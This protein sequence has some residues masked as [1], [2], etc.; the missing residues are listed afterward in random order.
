MGFFPDPNITTGGMAVFEYAN[1]VTNG[2]FG[3]VI[4]GATFGVS[5][6]S[7]SGYA[8]EKT[9][10]SSLFVTTIVA[11]LLSAVGLVDAS[12]LTIFAL[13]TAAAFIMLTQKQPGY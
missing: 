4:V 7:L 2:L 9:I 11:L 13:A 5:F 12:V 10:V 3:V 1:T 6:L 8:K